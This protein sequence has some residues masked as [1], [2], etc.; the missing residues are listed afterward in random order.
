MSISRVGAITK[1]LVDA[2]DRICKKHQVTHSEYRK[3]IDFIGEAIDKGERSL[4]FDAFLEANVVASDPTKSAGTSPQ[5]LGPFYLPDMPWV[6]N[7]SLAKESEPGE[8]ITLNGRVL[9]RN[10]NPLGNAELD[11]WQADSNGRYSNFDAGVQD[12]NLRGKTRADED[13]SFLLHTVKPAQYT[14]PDQGPTGVLLS[15]IGRHSWRPAHFHVIVRHPGYK[16]LTT[17]IYFEGDKYLNSDA[18]H[19]ASPDLAFPVVSKGEGAALIFDLILE[20]G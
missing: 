2:I 8:R 14:I 16:M 18:V 9:D 1:D 3:A 5:V 7:N 15:E 17:Q 19:A 12:G 13:G 10:Q 4:L 11:F 20:S 6:K